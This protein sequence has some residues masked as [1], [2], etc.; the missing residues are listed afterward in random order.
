MYDGINSHSN[1]SKI[2]TELGQTCSHRQQ[3]HCCCCYLVNLT[4]HNIA[5]VFGPLAP[6]CESMIGSTQP[7]A[8]SSEEDRSTVTG[9]MYRKCGEI[10]TL[11]EICK[12]TDRHTDML[13]ALLPPYHWLVA[14]LSDR[15]S[16]FGRRTFSVLCSTCRWRVTTYVGKPSAM[17]QPTRPT[18]PF[19]PLG[20]RD[21]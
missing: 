19:I 11:F 3:L 8:L 15:T 5:L 16:V 14:W 2:S 10:W 9:D 4:R 6:S 13:M 21:E 12:R 7:I 18:Q 1:K 20:S 17:G